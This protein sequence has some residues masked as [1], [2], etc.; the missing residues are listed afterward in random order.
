MDAAIEIMFT[1]DQRDHGLGHFCWP[2]RRWI[3]LERP[4]EAA[5]VAAALGRTSLKMGRSPHCIGTGDGPRS[6][7]GS[8]IPS[9]ALVYW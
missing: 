5:L 8:S 3:S 7:F 6:R 1:A 2:A 4:F 9:Q